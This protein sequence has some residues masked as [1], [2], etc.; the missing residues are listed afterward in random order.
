[1]QSNRLLSDLGE[2]DYAALAPHL[3][4]VALERGK[5]LAEVGETQPYI[6]FPIEGV[7]SLVGATENGMTV[8]VADVGREGIASICAIFGSRC[9]PF[10]IVT[11]IA[12]RAM[13]LP[14]EIAARQLR[15]CGALHSRLLESAEAIIT[16]ISQAAVCNRY[17]NAKERLA[18]WLLTTAQ[19]AETSA[20]PLTHEFISSMV[21]GP[22]S[23]VTEAS[24]ELRE[25]GAIDYSRGLLLITDM[26]KLQSESCEC[27]IAVGGQP[28]AAA[29]G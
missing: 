2:Q 10:R 22:R 27:Y 16:Q 15:E 24:A 13:R 6:Y 12:G 23:A 14:T 3:Q 8:E 29:G 5:V 11:K 20:L 25:S 17:H 4:E 1:V 9:T 28:V 26:A 18:R 21:G 19:R 7:L